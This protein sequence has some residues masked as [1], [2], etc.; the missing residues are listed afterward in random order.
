MLTSLLQVCWR[1]IFISLLKD[2]RR[3]DI[4]KPDCLLKYFNSYMYSMHIYSTNWSTGGSNSQPTSKEWVPRSTLL[5][6]SSLRLSL[7]SPSQNRYPTLT[8]HPLSSTPSSTHVASRPEINTSQSGKHLSGRL[9][10]DLAYG[11]PTLR[12]KRRF[13]T[14]FIARPG[15]EP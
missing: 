14:A 9:A 5:Q 2:M 3:E 7:L 12:D 15:T 8:E 6:K 11:K 4:K 1:T 13:G 10:G